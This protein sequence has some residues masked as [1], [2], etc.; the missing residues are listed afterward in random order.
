MISYINKDI[1]LA[2]SRT[3]SK[4]QTLSYFV[5]HIAV[6]KKSVFLF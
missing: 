1:I 4:E 2:V 3:V 5:M 6:D